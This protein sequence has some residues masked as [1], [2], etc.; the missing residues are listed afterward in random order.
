MILA[1]SDGFVGAFCF[2]LGIARKIGGALTDVSGPK[3][4]CS[5]LAF[6]MDLNLSID[7]SWF[8]RTLTD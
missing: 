6:T 2:A 8:D 5:I 3:F 7:E 4:Q 1:S